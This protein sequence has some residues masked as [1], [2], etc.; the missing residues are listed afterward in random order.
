MTRVNFGPLDLPRRLL[1]DKS[2]FLT[3]G[4]AHFGARRLLG[5]KSEFW[6]TGSA[7]FGAI[8]LL[9]GEQKTRA[10]RGL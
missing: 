1:G 6:T 10:F 4:P 7:H 2:E 5:D 3:T 9:V 8:E